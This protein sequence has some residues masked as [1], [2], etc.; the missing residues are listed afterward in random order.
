M[1]SHWWASC[2]RSV[3]RR[4]PYPLAYVEH[5]RLS[6]EEEV[7]HRR[8]RH[9]CRRLG[10]R[11][12]RDAPKPDLRVQVG[13]EHALRR[14][15]CR[16]VIGPPVAAPSWRG[17]TSQRRPARERWFPPVTRRRPRGSR[18]PLPRRPVRAAGRRPRR[19]FGTGR[20][21]TQR[22]TRSGAASSGERQA[23]T[24][25][26]RARLHAPDNLAHLMLRELFLLRC[27]AVPADVLTAT[28][29]PCADTE[30]RVPS[31]TE[32]AVSSASVTRCGAHSTS[33]VTNSGRVEAQ[34]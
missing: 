12:R 28:S 1:I 8:D 11:A 20:G 29:R 13:S 22:G 10:V 9:A 7:V 27:R 2:R 25:P 17:G 26:P 18:S 16:C 21:G 32:A 5:V 33:E 24:R 3:W 15:Q 19:P 34:S 23:E 4:S 31:R 6:G 30:T 14:G